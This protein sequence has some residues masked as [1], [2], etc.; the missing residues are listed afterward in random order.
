MAEVEV[1]GELVGLI[2]SAGEDG[3]L[4]TNGLA[5]CDSH[6][7]QRRHAM[8]LPRWRVRRFD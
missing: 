7:E 8:A 6:E 1:G 2:V 4:A 5:D 3:K